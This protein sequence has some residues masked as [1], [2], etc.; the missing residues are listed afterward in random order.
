[1]VSGVLET[2]A[3]SLVFCADGFSLFN[4]SGGEAMQGPVINKVIMNEAGYKSMRL[5]F[6]LVISIPCKVVFG[7][8]ICTS[9]TVFY[10]FLPASFPRSLS[11]PLS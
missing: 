2:A 11:L 9:A 3:A 6:F 10:I 4:F 7:I 5:V 8:S 1:M